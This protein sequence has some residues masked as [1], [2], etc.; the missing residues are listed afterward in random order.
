[1]IFHFQVLPI[2]RSE[3]SKKVQDA[4]QREDLLKQAVGHEN[5]KPFGAVIEAEMV[6][7]AFIHE[8]YS[9]H[10]AEIVAN[11]MTTE[12]AEAVDALLSTGKSC[13]RYSR[14]E[15]ELATNYFSDAKKIGEGGYGVVYRCTLD[16]TEV[17]V[18][19]S[20]KIPGTRLMS[21]SK[22]YFLV[23]IF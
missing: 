10:E 3:D 11:M 6:K 18:K 2:E 13:R 23:Y 7:E 17:A 12:K 21:S 8:A 5:S 9:K 4:L 22:R 20:S 15:I 14:L 19:V 1:M 16:H